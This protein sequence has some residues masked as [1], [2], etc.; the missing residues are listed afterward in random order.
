[1]YEDSHDSSSASEYSRL[2]DPV[3]LEQTSPRANSNLDDNDFYKVRSDSSTPRKLMNR[4][5]SVIL[6]NTGERVRRAVTLTLPQDFD[7]SHETIAYRRQSNFNHMLQIIKRIYFNNVFRGVFKCSMAYFLASLGV[8]DRS[9]DDFLGSTDSKHV[10]ATVAVYFHPSRSRGSMNQTLLFVIISLVFSITVSLSCR[11]ISAVVYVGGKDEV[12][13][14]IDLIVSSVAL[15]VIAF[16]KQKVNKQTFNTACS[17]ACITIVSC[18]V[19]EGSISSGSIPTERIEATF[20]VVI[21]GCIISLACCYLIWPE[22]A[23]KELQHTLNDS[24]KNYS[25]LLLVLTRRFVAGEQ[26]NARDEALIDKLKK[27][28]TSMQQYLEETKYELC[29]VGKEAEWEYYKRLVQSTVS[30][31][32]HLQALSSATRMQWSLL[33][34]TSGEKSTASTL[35]SYNSDE[36]E[37]SSSIGQFNSPR[38]RVEETDMASSLQ[39]FDLFVYHLAP[40]IKSLVFTVRDVL[41]SLPLGGFVAAEMT[42]SSNYQTALASA[43]EMY[44]TRQVLSFEHIYNQE[45]FTQNENFDFKADQEEVAACCGNFATLLSQFASGM[46]ECLKLF[47]EHHDAKTAPRS[48]SWIRLE[49]GKF[50]K[51]HHSNATSLHAAL[52]DLRDQYGIP[53]EEPHFDSFTERVSYRIWSRF[54][55]LK[56]ADVQFG[57]RVGLGAACL[58]LFAFVPATKEIFEN[59]R[60]EWALTVYCIMMNK[61]LGGTSMTVKWRIIGTFIGAFVAFSTWTIFEANVYVLAFTGIL[62]SIPSFYIILFWKQNNPFG[63]FILL[64]YN[65][66]MLYSYSMLQK[67]AED[68]FEGGENPII[69]EI[70]FHRFAAVSIGIIWA[71]TMAT[72]FL[73]NSAR[74]RLKNGLSILWLRL[75][76]IWNSDPLEYNP[77]TM[78]LVGFKAEEGTNKILSE[79]ETLLKQAPVEFRLKG[80]F[81]TQTY[82]KLIKETSAIIDAFQNLDLLIKADPKLNSNEEYVL[83]YIEVERGEVEQRI[84]LVFYMIASAMKLGFSL[85]KKFASIEHA[86]DR[87]LYKLSEIRQQ[88]DNGF[89]LRN[90][91]FI[92]LYSYI[93]VA[94]TISEQLD[95]MLIDIKGLLGEISEDKFRLV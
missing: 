76:V 21:T 92:L 77:D 55:Y 82:A 46:L 38:T 85:P 2:M 91:D 39:L 62:I 20:K 3:E 10:I 6:A 41:N 56:R 63:R 18:I 78:E 93:L 81:P 57:L 89:V 9:F 88:Q 71:L 72:C 29:L 49:R 87:M 74:S 11:F 5:N 83:K 16:M 70:A 30:L 14:I 58:S 59:W 28:V 95:K 13:H 37:S 22:S 44:Q 15:G 94:S 68:E 86:K 67:D 66:T 75:G 31:A 32:R 35:R 65:L 7:V 1:M 19:K 33:S 40:S 64:T 36:L 4:Q 42:D 51:D 61:S 24:F 80:K 27:N 53:K 47:D 90:D 54:K 73:P 34:S 17:L 60:L 79:C 12:S 8:F 23:T 43:I 26:L 25:K 84:F 45:S 48:W 50:A 52:D 69:G